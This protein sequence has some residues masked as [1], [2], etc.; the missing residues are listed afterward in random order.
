MEQATGTPRVREELARSGLPYEWIPIDPEYADTASFCERYGYPLDHSA[1]TIVVASKKEPKRYAAC[2]LRADMRLDVNRAVR[3][4]L[5]V[6]R[7]SFADPDETMRL[8]GMTIGGV[9]VLALPAALPLYVD[10]R[11]MEL[12][13]VI[14][15]SGDRSAKI[16]I[17]PGVFRALP[18]ARIVADL[19]KA[20][21]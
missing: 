20:S 6:S 5:G 2:V 15:G 18:G 13:Y 1:N 21:P 7:L 12:D 17:S 11:L 10:D 4:L 14:L 16:K 8:T 3:Q 9:T 19:A